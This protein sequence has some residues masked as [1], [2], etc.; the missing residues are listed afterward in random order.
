MSFGADF[1]KLSTTDPERIKALLSDGIE[2]PKVLS[3]FGERIEQGLTVMPG[4]PIKVVEILRAHQKH[5]KD[6]IEDNEKLDIATRAQAY[7]LEAAGARRALRAPGVLTRVIG[8]GIEIDRVNGEVALAAKKVNASKGVKELDAVFLSYKNLKTAREV[9]N[10]LKASPAF[11]QIAKDEGGAAVREFVMRM[12]EIRGDRNVGPYTV[13][14]VRRL[15]AEMDSAVESV[16]PGG[17][18]ILD[19]R[20]NRV[21]D[22]AEKAGAFVTNPR[23][24]FSN[25]VAHLELPTSRLV[26]LYDE[27]ERKF[28]LGQS[29]GDIPAS[30]DTELQQNFQAKYG[31]S[32]DGVIADTDETEKLLQVRRATRDKESPRLRIDM[33]FMP[34]GLRNAPYIPYQTQAALGHAATGQW[35]G[36]FH[37]GGFWIL[38]AREL[39]A[40]VAE[41]TVA[42]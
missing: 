23:G 27:G 38:S 39:T 33:L 35:R 21:A 12:R 13:D 17:N 1:H 30:M 14:E 31:K 41:A 26:S 29:I 5:L 32:I 8:T 15:E 3:Y 34:A 9:E 22:Y 20:S 40:A 42:N 16:R 36:H 19:E 37:R 6:A 4:T 11:A 18:I 7:A 10:R 28:T 25:I 24:H 2:S